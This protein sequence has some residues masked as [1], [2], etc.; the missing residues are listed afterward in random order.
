[1]G[2]LCAEHSELQQKLEKK[3]RECDVKAQEKEEM[4]QTLSKMKE[5]L[6]KENNEHKLTKQQVA[7]LTAR[8]QELSS[9]RQHTHS[10]PNINTV[11][12]LKHTVNMLPLCIPLH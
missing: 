10:H 4:I 8:L 6:E 12:V 2:G 11:Y 1:M 3:E 7:S 9:V 5:K